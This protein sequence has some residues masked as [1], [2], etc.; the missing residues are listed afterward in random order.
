MSEAVSMNGAPRRPQIDLE[1]ARALAERLWGVVGDPEELPGDRD[2]NF[3]VGRG[4]DS[5]VLKVTDAPPEEIA[6]SVDALGLL[7]EAGGALMV[8]GAERPGAFASSIRTTYPP[9]AI[10]NILILR[11]VVL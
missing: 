5:M 2:R 1:A 6:L 8:G 9:G 7:G 3:R 4:S 11:G 10:L